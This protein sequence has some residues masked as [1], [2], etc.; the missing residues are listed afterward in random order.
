M[1][2]FRRVT[3]LVLLDTHSAVLLTYATYSVLFI[4]SK[5]MNCFS[6]MRHVPEISELDRF[7]AM[8]LLL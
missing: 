2:I 3:W 1:S 7:L 5:K 6:K 8:R 4:H